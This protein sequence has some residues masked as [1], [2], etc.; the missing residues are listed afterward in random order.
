MPPDDIPPIPP[1]DRA[2]HRNSSRPGSN[3]NHPDSNPPDSNHPDLDTV[4]DL[5]AGVLDVSTA[6]V[7]DAHVRGCPQCS[8]TLGV[9][10]SV[11]VELR[12]L[13]PPSLPPAV[14]SRLDETLARLHRDEPVRPAARDLHPAALTGHEP[15][16]PVPP[17]P[18][19]PQRPI[20]V[21]PVPAGHRVDPVVDL[22]VRRDRRLRARKSW[23]NVAAALVL[24]A[25]AVG[26][27]TALVR[28]SDSTDSDAGSSVAAGV[29]PGSGGLSG[30]RVPSAKDD[31]AGGGS[32]AEST[33]PPP[34]A[35]GLPQYE[36]DTVLL[37]A[38]PVIVSQSPVDVITGALNNNRAGVMADPDRRASCAG[39]VG[40]T[41]ADAIAVERIMYK[42]AQAYV[43]VFRGVDAA[44]PGVVVVGPT[45]GDGPA[46]VRYRGIR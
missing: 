44:H 42:G 32:P 24:V 8:A 39:A 34:D 19:P 45:C 21:P 31:H 9:L 36:S 27:G 46:D 43:F 16:Q 23:T 7:V 35:T 37:N 40:A 2:D 17:A 14:A 38:V 12:S 13:P 30:P 41:A 22:S 33:T 5:D 18:P 20:V 15:G 26:V 4:A 25:A 10:A 1:D 3:S 11:R 6:A 28:Q 29:A